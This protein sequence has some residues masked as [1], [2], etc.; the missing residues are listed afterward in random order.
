MIDFSKIKF[1]DKVYYIDV[2]LNVFRNKISFTDSD[3]FTWHRYPEPRKEFRI[4]ELEYI[5]RVETLTFGDVE[6]EDEC[7]T[8]YFR[9]PD[10]MSGSP[11]TYTIY[12]D[13]I[14]DEEQLWYNDREEAEHARI[15]MALENED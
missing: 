8:H 15:M 6:D 4:I 10:D 2:K 9:N 3:G 1:G 12:P 13:G 14:D 7:N 5:G 11:I